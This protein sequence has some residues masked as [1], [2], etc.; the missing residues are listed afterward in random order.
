MIK[1]LSE[2]F[3]FL[4]ESYGTGKLTFE[5]YENNEKTVTISESQSDLEP[6]K[7]KIIGAAEG[8][9]FIP[10]GTSRNNR[11]Y[12]RD[13]W[14]H[15]L[16]LDYVKN[17][18][19]SRRMVG[20]IGHHDKKVDDEDFAQGLVSHVVTILKIDETTG[21]GFGR[22]EI[23][24]TPAG[25]LL[26]TYYDAGIPLCVSTRGAG[27]LKVVQGHLLKHVDKQNYYLETVDI[28]S[29]AGFPDAK[30]TLVIEPEN[31]EVQHNDTHP[32]DQLRQYN[33]NENIDNTLNQESINDNNHSNINEDVETMTIKKDE[34]NESV[35]NVNAE[36]KPEDVLKELL[37]PLQEGL[38]SV[39]GMLETLQS[40]LNESTEEKK[41][42]ELLE[43]KL[44]EV[45]EKLSKFPEEVVE[46]FDNYVIVLKEEHEKEKQD[47]DDKKKCEEELEK[48][49]ES[50]MEKIKEFEKIVEEH[51]EE[52]KKLTEE[53][54]QLK[55]EYGKEK[56]EHE[57]KEK[58]H[59]KTKEEL[60]ESLHE[61]NSIKLSE[62][63]AITR[64]E[65]KEK[66]NE[67][68]YEVIVEEL[69]KEAEDK[70]EAEKQ[71]AEKKLQE[72]VENNISESAPKQSLFQNRFINESMTNKK[73]TLFKNRFQK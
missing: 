62:G 64:E 12:P 46:N 48:V 9:F 21:L 36:M 18:I 67:K 38:G 28:V 51:A 4:E 5:F 73:E 25:R 55:E 15:I 41:K 31:I 56:Q 6:K 23:L 44:T 29:E 40:R 69:E 35:S 71:E 10:N 37:N 20:T 63:Y 59:E 47:Q 68:A 3:D 26:K 45:S 66:L 24:D 57:E 70:K 34:L 13:F 1:L 27:K 72:K 42:S 14:E 2:K 11:F 43:S 54:N 8:T 22:L 65:A 49:V 39:Q 32:P 17:K 50:M 58:E 19:A 16:S 61:I 33:T 52:R 30:P 60:K 7:Y 53:Y